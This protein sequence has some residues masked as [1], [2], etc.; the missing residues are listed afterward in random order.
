MKDFLDNFVKG[1]SMMFVF[2]SL[3]QLGITSILAVNCL[4]SRLKLPGPLPAEVMD[5][6]L[7]LGRDNSISDSNG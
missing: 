7:D 4:L 5:L 2:M 1:V 6:T 3:M